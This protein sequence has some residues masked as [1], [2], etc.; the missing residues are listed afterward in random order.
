MF[1]PSEAEKI[2]LEL[3][4]ISGK[5]DQLP[6]YVDFNFKIK[7]G[8]SSF[9]LKISTEDDLALL[10]SQNKV[11]LHL[12]NGPGNFPEPVPSLKG[13]DIYKLEHHGEAYHIRLLTYV[14][15]LPIFK[16]KPTKN[17]SYTLGRFLGNLDQKLM[18]FNDPVIETRVYK[19]DIQHLLLNQKYLR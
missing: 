16:V 1:T 12:K 6:G 10:K 5:A 3:Y 13:K 18:S 19:W 9:V 8:D 11:L 7:S 17:I 14:D 4:G 2:A 15:G